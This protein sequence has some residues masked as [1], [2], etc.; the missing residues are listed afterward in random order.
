M[1]S[2][3][4]FVLVV[5]VVVGCR[6]S[7]EVDTKTPNNVAAK[8]EEK[9]ADTSVI[10]R[11][12]WYANSASEYDCDA[13]K[14]EYYPGNAGNFDMILR[15][16]DAAN[17]T[18]KVMTE[19]ASDD[20]QQKEGFI[21]LLYFCDELAGGT[22][23]FKTRKDG[24]PIEVSVTGNASRNPLLFYETGFKRLLEKMD[25]KNPSDDFVGE[26][27]DEEEPEKDELEETDPM[28][29]AKQECVDKI[30]AFRATIGMRPLQR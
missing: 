27:E 14:K 20:T 6:A 11:Y 12:D 18:V 1:K 19:Y 24:K 7:V 15:G 17:L 21:D 13:L 8:P 4:C 10:V 23:I 29:I 28:E 22:V 5:F 3:A 25:G 16:A 30:N 26:E 2:F 9:P